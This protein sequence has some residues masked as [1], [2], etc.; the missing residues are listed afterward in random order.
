M[1]EAAGPGPG[2]R[3]MLER[4]SAW[5]AQAEPAGVTLRPAVFL[6]TDEGVRGGSGW[7][8]RAPATPGGLGWRN[9]LEWA[10][11]RLRG[12]APL[13]ARRIAMEVA[14]DGEVAANPHNGTVVVVRGGVVDK[15]HLKEADAFERL[16]GVAAPAIPWAEV[17]AGPGLV[18]VR[19]PRFA[20]FPAGAGDQELLAAVAPALQSLHS[21]SARALEDGGG[22]FTLAAKVRQLFAFYGG[23]AVHALP[24]ALEMVRRLEERLDAFPRVLCHGDLWRG[25]VLLDGEGRAVLVDVDKALLAP[26]C[27]DRVH[28][29]LLHRSMEEG[30]GAERLVVRW[31]WPAEEAERF[32]ARGAGDATPAH[33]DEIRAGALLFTFLKGVELAARPGARRGVLTALRVVLDRAERTS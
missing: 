27:Y 30:M 25:N 6:A 33:T 12:R 18:R 16:Y 7:D 1:A 2:A 19:M 5:Y 17:E 22:L 11:S 26:P 24:A 8:G 23:D 20:P 9:A 31:P 3:A 13:Y 10:R 29:R 15:F 4:V 21:C 28:L 32:L 14:F